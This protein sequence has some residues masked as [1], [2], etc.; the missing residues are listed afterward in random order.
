MTH[1]SPGPGLPGSEA[2]AP[3]G[4]L[5]HE[6]RT[7]LASFSK[8]S[9]MKEFMSDMALIPARTPGCPCVGNAN[10]PTERLPPTGGTRMGVNGGPPGHTTCP[11][12]F[13]DYPRPSLG[14][15]EQPSCEHVACPGD[16]RARR[17]HEHVE[18]PGC[19]PGTR[20]ARGAPKMEAFC[21]LEFSFPGENR[22][23]PRVPG[24]GG[25]RDSRLR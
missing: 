21:L 16:A 25:P 18:C 1:P 6:T 22:R 8:M 15:P 13:R 14:W 23:G 24:P 20:S 12:A 7:A 4:S 2:H 9:L 10:I 17:D 3:R 11:G 19:S 5:L